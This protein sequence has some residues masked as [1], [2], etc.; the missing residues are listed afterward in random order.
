[1]ECRISALLGRPPS[2]VRALPMSDLAL[3]SRYWAHEPWGAWRDNVHAGFIAAA[4]TNGGMRRPKKPVAWK[5]F[6]L[7]PPPSTLERR[8]RGLGLVS[9]LRALAVGKKE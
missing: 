5:D 6:M 2:E 4:I 8:K 1:M 9:A 7:K 3:L